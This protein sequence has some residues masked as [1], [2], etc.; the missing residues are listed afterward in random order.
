MEYSFMTFQDGDSRENNL[1][2]LESWKQLIGKFTLIDVIIMTDDG[3]ESKIKCPAKVINVMEN[4][5][6]LVDIDDNRVN[7]V[8]DIKNET[9]N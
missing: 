2:E 5:M 8:K 9:Y 7:D 4:G 1:K 6:V 3:E